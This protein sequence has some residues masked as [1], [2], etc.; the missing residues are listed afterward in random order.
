MIFRKAMFK[1]VEAIHKLINDQADRGLMLPRAR[2]VIYETLRDMILADEDGVVVGAGG[3]HLIWDE[4]AEIRALAVVPES[5]GQGIGRQIVA[6]LT[7]EARELGV[8]TLF[9]LTYQ[10]EFF[11]KQGFHEIPKEKLPHKVWK[12]CINCPKFPNCDEVAM[13]KE[14]E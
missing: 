13:V 4:L 10:T 1:D 11:A 8:K 14:L 12:E 9:A 6:R 7:E 3:L 2:N 5:A